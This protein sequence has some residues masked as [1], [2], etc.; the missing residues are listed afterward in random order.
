MLHQSVNPVSTCYPDLR[1]PVRKVQIGEWSLSFVQ[2]SPALSEHLRPI[3][4][5]KRLKC[6]QFSPARKKH[7]LIQF[8]AHS[9]AAT[10]FAVTNY[11]RCNLAVSHWRQ[12]CVAVLSVTLPSMEH[13]CLS[14]NK[15]V[16]SCKRK[17]PERRGVGGWWGHT[18][19]LQQKSLGR[20]GPAAAGLQSRPHVR[21]QADTLP[22][23]RTCTAPEIQLFTCAPDSA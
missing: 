10:F 19:P 8:D 5:R 2:S 14:N 13:Q 3:R 21:T 9:Q 1:G 22:D 18:H 6:M 16:V 7:M 23:V 20:C 12:F 11:K 15:S 4:M 17:H